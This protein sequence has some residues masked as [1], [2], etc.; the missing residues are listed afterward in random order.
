MTLR[1]RI[2]AGDTDIDAMAEWL[3]GL[4]PEVRRREAEAL[5]AKAQRRLW[6]LAR[7]RVVELDHF[8]PPD[9]G[10]MTSVR[11]YGRNTLPAFTL[12]EKRFCRPPE[13]EDQS[14]LWGYNEGIT[15]AAVGPGYFVVRLTGGDSRGE[16]VIDYTRVPPN[17]PAEWPEIRFNERGISRFV[18]AGMLD[19][20]RGVSKHV[21]IGRAYRKDRETPNCFV[22]CREP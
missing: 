8:A 13:G 6:R 12:F 15:R 16:S 7:G 5:D 4:D 10:P 2:M 21:S 19:F 3:D 1:R 14:T 17:K 22:L 11:H 18:Y 9:R 20:M